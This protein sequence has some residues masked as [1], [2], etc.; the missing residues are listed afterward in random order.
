MLSKFVI[1]FLPRS[2]RFLISWLQSPS[3]VILE[4]K[5]IKFVTD[6]TF[7]LSTWNEMMEPEGFPHVSDGKESTCNARDMG[8]ILGLGRCPGGRH[9][10]PLQYFCLENPHGQRSLAN[11]SPSGHKKSDITEQLS[12]STR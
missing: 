10:N 8:S 11:Y 1:A 9:G 5:K 3:A 6:S 4:P 12:T 7:P 2:K